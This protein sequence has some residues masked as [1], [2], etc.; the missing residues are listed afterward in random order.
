MQLSKYFEQIWFQKNLN[1][2]SD[3]KFNSQGNHRT[4]GSHSDPK[5]N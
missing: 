2:H 1:E 5:F 4:Y 3:P